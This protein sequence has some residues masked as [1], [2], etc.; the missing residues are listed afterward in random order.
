MGVGAGAEAG[1]LGWEEATCVGSCFV[2]RAL[3][4]VHGEC[5]C[6]VWIYRDSNGVPKGDGTGE[7]CAGLEAWWMYWA[8]CLQ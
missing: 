4:I 6:Q 3:T 5:S 2:I 1:V 8:W 7:C